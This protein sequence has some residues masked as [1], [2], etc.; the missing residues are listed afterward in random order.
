MF[1]LKEIVLGIVHMY[2]RKQEG[3]GF[4]AMGFS[5]DRFR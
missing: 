3:Y 2:L 5:G 4:V 1:L